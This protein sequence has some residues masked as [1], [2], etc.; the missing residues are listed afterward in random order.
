MIDKDS[1]LKPGRWC[2]IVQNE[3]EREQR[4]E[5]GLFLEKDGLGDVWMVVKRGS[6]FVAG[7]YSIGDLIPLFSC[8][9]WDYRP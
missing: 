7:Q 5:I 3:S 6:G 8:T 1:C 4:R 9:G 2:W